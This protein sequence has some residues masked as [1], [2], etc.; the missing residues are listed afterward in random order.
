MQQPPNFLTNEYFNPRKS[1]LTKIKINEIFSAKMFHNMKKLYKILF[2]GGWR[3]FSGGEE[4]GRAAIF[5]EGLF[6]GGKF[7]SG[8]FPGGIFPGGIFPGD[9][10][11]STAYN[12]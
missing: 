12:W 7:P 8:T 9:I 2:L 1:R 10:F 4:G 11:P 3:Q 6:P 5:L